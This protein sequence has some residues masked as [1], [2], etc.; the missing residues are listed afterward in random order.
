[1]ERNI[2]DLAVVRE[3]F[4]SAKAGDSQEFHFNEE[5]SQEV[6]SKF[7][8]AINTEGAPRNIWITVIETFPK[9]NPRTRLQARCS[10]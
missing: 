7:A 4:T 6:A 5:I 10:H 8:L 1:M 9:P 3:W 2:V